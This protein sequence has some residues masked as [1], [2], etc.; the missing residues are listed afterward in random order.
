MLDLHDEDDIQPG[1]LTAQVIRA[2][3]KD[4][5]GSVTKVTSSKMKLKVRPRIDDV[6][7]KAQGNTIEI[8]IDTCPASSSSSQA[9]L[10]LLAMESGKPRG[11]H[12]T[13]PMI[14]DGR[15]RFV[16]DNS[17]IRKSEYIVT[18]KINGVSSPFDSNKRITIT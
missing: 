11:Y 7:V 17:D 16:L 14:S 8:I 2:V 13:S 9:V 18:I 1:I 5:G 15:Y 4:D 12:L 10:N 3:D 6:S